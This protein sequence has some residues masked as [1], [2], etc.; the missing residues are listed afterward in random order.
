MSA[1]KK[2]KPR[3]PESSAFKDMLRRLMK[4]PKRELDEKE[5]EYQRERATAKRQKI[6]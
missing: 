4:V 3:P 6:G 1:R 5:A 2:P